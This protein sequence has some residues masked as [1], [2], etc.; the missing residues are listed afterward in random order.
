MFEYLVAAF[1]ELLSL[2][3]D[4]YREL[5]DHF[6]RAPRRDDRVIEGRARR[7]HTPESRL[8]ALEAAHRMGIVHRDIKP[9]NIIV[10]KNGDV[11]IT[12]FGIARITA[13]SHTQTGIVKGTPYYM[14][15][16]QFSGAK[17][18][19]RSDIFSLGTMLFQLLTGTLPFFS[20]SPAVLMNQI[21]NF[22]HPNP[23]AINP[24]VIP[25]VVAIVDKALEKDRAHRYQTARELARDLC[26]LDKRIMAVLRKDRARSVSG[27]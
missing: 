25:A 19:G 22:P 16:E 27:K 20:E 5:R 14:S 2:F 18:D 6:S 4:F 1:K 10:L 17:V 8:R 9:A 15:P 12:D 11:K 26:R 13:S 24:R 21:M 7:E 23:R 3:G